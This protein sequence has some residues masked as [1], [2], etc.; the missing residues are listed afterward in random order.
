VLKAGFIASVLSSEKGSNSISL[1]ANLCKRAGIAL[2]CY[3][4]KAGF[5]ACVLSSEKGSPVKH[6]C[7]LV[8][9]GLVLF[10]IMVA[11]LL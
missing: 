7:P 3:M 2:S 5:I 8:V 11:K 4:L 1:V 10:Y 9:R 6:C